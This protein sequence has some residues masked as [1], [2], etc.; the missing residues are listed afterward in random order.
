[1]EYDRLVHSGAQALS[2]EA[3]GT[4]PYRPMPNFR[5]TLLKRCITAPALLTIAT[6]V[7]GADLRFWNAGSR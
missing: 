3:D 4:Y 1:M 6:R 7:L 5:G 2:N